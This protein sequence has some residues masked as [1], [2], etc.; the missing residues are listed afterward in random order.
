MPFE[1]AI[2]QLCIFGQNHMKKISREALYATLMMN[3]KVL[4]K[5]F[6]FLH[7]WMSAKSDCNQTN[8]HVKS[9]SSRK[10]KR[11]GDGHM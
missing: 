7:K 6:E 8:I 3:K 2:E 11:F 5:S 9:E 4:S 10:N 1:G